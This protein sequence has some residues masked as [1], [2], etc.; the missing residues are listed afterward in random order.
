[1]LIGG[2]ARV[3]HGSDEVTRG[4]DI[5]PAD[6]PSNLP[7]LHAALEAVEA[8]GPRGRAPGALDVLGAS[9][10]PLSTAHGELK[11]V[12][13]PAG[14]AGY[15]DLRRRAARQPIGE[16][17]RPAVAAPGE[18]ARMLEALGRDGDLAKLRALHRIIELDRGRGREL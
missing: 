11:I 10:L 8:R 3:L 17:L 12:P 18:L 15:P 14:T 13:Q 6:R 7:R 5:T 16:G 1:M 9:L 4:V 2:L